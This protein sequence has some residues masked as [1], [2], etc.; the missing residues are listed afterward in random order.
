[1]SEMAVAMGVLFGVSV[2]IILIVYL[3]LSP[4][5]KRIKDENARTMKMLLMIPLEV[6]DNVPAI[7]EYLETGQQENA[8]KKLAE[9]LSEN[10]A[11]SRSIVDSSVDAIIVMNENVSLFI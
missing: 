9:E 11:R 8:K 2:P 6:I 4:L 3:T 10:V 7:K 5:E 1:M